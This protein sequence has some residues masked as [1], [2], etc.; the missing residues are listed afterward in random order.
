MLKQITDEIYRV[1]LPHLRQQ[2]VHSYLIKGEKGFTVLD[3]GPQTEEARAIWRKLLDDGL[4]IEKV[5]VTHGHTDHIG[6]ASWF[7]REV[8]VPVIF[9]GIGFSRLKKIRSQV[10]DDPE[11]G[12]A[13][14]AFFRQH[15]GPDIP[16]D[17]LREDAVR[18]YFEPDDVYEPGG[19]VTIGDK[20]F[21]AIWTPGHA[22]DQFCF[23]N[24]DAGLLFSGDH[25]LDNISP[26]IPMWSEE[27]GS[28]LHDYLSSLDAVE[29][30]EPQLAL[31]GH[32]ELIADWRARGK[33]LRDGH[34][35]RLQQITDILKKGERTAWQIAQEIYGSEVTGLQALL[36]LT[37]TISRLTYLRETG[38][39]T[40]RLKDDGKLYFAV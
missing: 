30:Y 10:L 40:C 1:T 23:W 11:S 25:V 7:Q 20:E 5:V 36:V 27:D 16:A 34:H 31:P 2:T 35:R 17:K 14:S 37:G 19:T 3:T 15:G 9:S 32:G 18:D 8:K 29:H 21:T 24:G 33:E 13:L 39:V 6:L 4:A 26:V 38:K 12:R 28:P 22:Q